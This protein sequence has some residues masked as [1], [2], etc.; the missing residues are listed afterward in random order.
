[1]LKIFWQQLTMILPILYIG[2]RNIGNNQI[3]AFILFIII[4]GKEKNKMGL[5]TL[6]FWNVSIIILG[7]LVSILGGRFIV[8]NIVETLWRKYMPPEFKTKRN[9]SLVAILGYIENF[10]F[11]TAILINIKEFIAVWLAL[12]IVG[13]WSQTKTETD[14]PLYYIFM[15]GNGLSLII[16]CGAGLMVAQLIR[17]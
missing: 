15:I 14:R 6:S 11:T 4:M 2:S 3:P 9:G 1:V 8:G 5:V 10:L 12:K 7:Y 16:S 17:P 13:E